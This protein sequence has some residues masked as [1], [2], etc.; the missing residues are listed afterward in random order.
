LRD[1]ARHFRGREGALETVLHQGGLA[2]PFLL[3]FSRKGEDFHFVRGVADVPS[4]K[5]A[6]PLS[7]GRERDPASGSRKCPSRNGALPLSAGRGRWRAGVSHESAA[8]AQWSPA[9]CGRARVST[10]WMGHIRLG[11][12]MVPCLAPQGGAAVS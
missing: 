6:L 1:R 3:C 2:P 4:R 10:W 11:A 8:Q 7:A 12:A 5:G 9:F